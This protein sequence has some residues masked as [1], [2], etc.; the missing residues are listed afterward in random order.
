MLKK[1]GWMDGWMDGWCSRRRSNERMRMALIVQTKVKETSD[2]TKGMRKRD[3]NSNLYDATSCR[4][5]NVMRSLFK[6]Y[7]QSGRDEG[8]R[9]DDRIEL[10][11]ELEDSV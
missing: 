9:R 10:E 8:K 1:R 2:N 4:V 6:Q 7:A 5:R 11:L 3:P